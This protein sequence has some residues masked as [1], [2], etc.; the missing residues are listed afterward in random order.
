MP[1][2]L[3]HVV[4]VVHN[5]E[6]AV[7]FFQELG[8]EIEGAMPISGDWVD[9]VNGLDDVRVEITMM[10]TPDGNGKLELTRF[11]HPAVPR[12]EPHP[13]NT[14]GLRSIMFEV[15]DLDDALARLKGRGGELV[16]EIATYDDV[17]RLCYMR[18]PGGVI[19]ALAQDLR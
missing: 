14:V 17:Y 16:G 7:A 10:R 19:V 5:M 3:D 13:P 11:D 12:T 8:M 15:D 9:R 1:L 2:R 6:A 18:G 4:V